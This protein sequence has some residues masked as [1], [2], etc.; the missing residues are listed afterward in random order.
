MP[1]SDF[2]QGSF[3]HW[4]PLSGSLWEDDKAK[5]A[6]VDVRQRKGLNPKVPELNDYLDKLQG[7]LSLQ[8]DEWFVVKERNFLTIELFRSRKFQTFVYG[9]ELTLCRCSCTDSCIACSIWFPGLIIAVA[10]L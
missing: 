2:S 10:L 4:E 8:L 9:V 1:A 6:V 7:E 3:D 5:D